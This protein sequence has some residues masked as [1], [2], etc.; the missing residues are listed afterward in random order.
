MELEYL[1]LSDMAAALPGFM[2]ADEKKVRHD[3][4]TELR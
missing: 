3:D 2:V 4:I 1:E